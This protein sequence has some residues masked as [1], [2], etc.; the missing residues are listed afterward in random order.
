MAIGGAR[1]FSKEAKSAIAVMRSLVISEKG[2][3]SLFRI[4]SDFRKEEGH[5]LMYKDFGYRSAAEFLE[6]S[7]EFVLRE[8][9]GETVVF[10]KPSENS[11]HIQ[12]MIAAQKSTKPKPKKPVYTNSWNKT[13]YQ[14][15]RYPSGQQNFTFQQPKQYGSS[16]YQ[17]SK[18]S[19]YQQQ[20]PKPF[21]Q[22]QQP[23][24]FFQ[25]Q[26]QQQPKPY[27]QQL[28]KP[29]VQQPQPRPFF[30]QQQPKPFVQQQQPKP[31]L[32]F[33]PQSKPVSS[34]QQKERFNSPNN[35]LS[36]FFNGGSGNKTSPPKPTPTTSNSS[37]NPFLLTSS[38]PFVTP[39]EPTVKPPLEQPKP[40][41]MD[42]TPVLTPTKAALPPTPR[43][44]PSTPVCGQKMDTTENIPQTGFKPAA[45]T[46]AQ[47]VSVV[48]HT[49]KPSKVQDRLQVWSLNEPSTS[50]AS[51]KFSW[52]QPG[53]TAVQLLNQYGQSYGCLPIYKF[54]EAKKRFH[55]K[56]T[57][58]GTVYRTYPDDYATTLESQTVVALIAIAAIRRSEDNQYI[59]CED[60]DEEIAA[61]IHDLL[62]NCRYGMLFN[63]IPNAFRDAYGMLLPKHWKVVVQSKFKNLFKTEEIS[64]GT[65]HNLNVFAFNCVKLPWDEPYWDLYV[66]NPVSPDEVWA[67]L[68][69]ADYSDEMDALMNRIEESMMCNKRRPV[70]V[71]AGEHYLVHIHD[72]WHRVR[73]EK[74]DRARNSCHCF[75]TDIGGSSPVPLDMMYVCE[76]RDL[77]LPGQAVC[78]TLDGLDAM[79]DDAGV[80]EHLTETI[81][82]KVLKGAI[83]TRQDQY[84]AGS[85]NM[86]IRVTLYDTSGSED[87]NVNFVL[88]DVF[89]DSMEL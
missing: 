34:F 67:R 74:V 31:A 39:A 47:T 3:S 36:S 62:V 73:A 53:A 65:G 4:L 26:Q 11:V 45:P 27:F 15:N 61:K 23:K 32:S 24:P 83:L 86:L 78:F 37:T 87:V 57:I 44:P 81:S 9:M 49:V 13:P 7:G 89:K 60:P 56:V 6:A 76:P 30:Q 5:P 64:D 84:E 69:G 66:T 50:T 17:Q 18:P 52:D 79:V 21:F 33:Q 42:S 40:T 71:N 48:S 12:Q 10:V 19:Y 85:G 51:A 54:F 41:R 14:T 25:Q 20:Q 55:C 46:P 43:A 29:F 1:E 38:N 35:P 70:Q 88:K 28:P 80:N 77:I 75:F 68:V 16:S 2:T 8:Q 22:Q 63:N 58:N 72:S 59:V 82:G